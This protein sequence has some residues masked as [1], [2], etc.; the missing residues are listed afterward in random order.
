VFIGAPGFCESDDCDAT[1][2]VIVCCV[3][4]VFGVGIVGGGL[5]AELSRDKS[6]E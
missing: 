1:G 6:D 2:F 3:A 4:V 5:Y